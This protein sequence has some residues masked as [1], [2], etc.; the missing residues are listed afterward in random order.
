MYARQGRKGAPAITRELLQVQQR[1][2]KYIEQRPLRWYHLIVISAVF[3]LPFVQWFAY[4]EYRTRL[5][6]LLPLAVAAGVMFIVGTLRPR[7]VAADPP[8]YRETGLRAAV[9]AAALITLLALPPSRTVTVLRGA[10][11]DI[12]GL[13]IVGYLVRVWNAPKMKAGISR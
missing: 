6:F 8:N 4:F 11:S 7:F 5:S 3:A 1:L 13:L 9:L 10:L 12:L 2:P